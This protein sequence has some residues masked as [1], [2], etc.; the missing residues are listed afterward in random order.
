MRVR[1]RDFALS[2]TGEEEGQ[3][4]SLERL[5]IER[6]FKQAAEL[7]EP[8]VSI[9]VA[10]LPPDAALWLGAWLDK[11]GLQIDRDGDDWFV[12]KRG[13]PGAALAARLGVLV[14]VLLPPVLFALFALF[15]M[16]GNACSPVPEGAEMV[17]GDAALTAMLQIYTGRQVSPSDLV[18]VY[19][20]PADP[21]CEGEPKVF[22]FRE[23]MSGACIAAFTQVNGDR[24]I[25]LVEE[26][27]LRLFSVHLPH[28]AMHLL[29]FNH[30]GVDWP[31]DSDTGK[32]I[33]R[34]GAW[35]QAHP[36]VD[37]IAEDPRK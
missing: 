27:R 18:P 30:A 3:G 22:A 31:A 16:L 8:G 15:T 10:I 17:N 19:L 2:I 13:E 29:G 21:A 28:E 1:D 35:L 7:L 20:V 34:A 26:S 24:A 4:P 5:L 36:D 32:Q 6:S 12:T 9:P 37:H 23:P 25:Y 11:M 33:A 14:H